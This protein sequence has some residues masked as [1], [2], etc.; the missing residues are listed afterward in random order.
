MVV[1]DWQI[2]NYSA[3]YLSRLDEAALEKRDHQIL[4]LLDPN[5]DDEIMDIGA[6]E[7]RLVFLLAPK[8]KRVVAVES[9]VQ[10]IRRARLAARRSGFIN[11]SF[12]VAGFLDF[13]AKPEVFS[14]IVT[15]DYLHHLMDVQKHVAI[16]RIYRALR[17]GGVLLIQDI[18]L[19]FPL[20]ALTDR[21][22]GI[23][24]TITNEFGPEVASG[25]SRT[26]RRQHPTSVENL[27]GILIKAGFEI[28]LTNTQYGLYTT[29]HCIKQ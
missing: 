29:F 13:E 6:G 14:K 25:F 23:L 2:D 15:R 10:S 11:I 26:L 16:E 17:P 18:A 1:T 24:D 20:T 22:P 12:Q 3:K 19:P 5:H 4:E 9:S 28:S 27:E 7:G 21:S 8:V